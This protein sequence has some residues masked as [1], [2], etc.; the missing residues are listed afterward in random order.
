MYVKHPFFL[1]Q[2]WTSV[3]L[4]QVTA[5]EDFSLQHVL[6]FTPGEE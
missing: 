5:V 3:W 1:P 6:D 2:T 4:W